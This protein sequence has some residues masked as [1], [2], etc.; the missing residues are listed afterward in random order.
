MQIAG[1][2]IIGG[3]LPPPTITAAEITAR[4]G[5]IAQ[6]ACYWPGAEPPALQQSLERLDQSLILARSAD[7]AALA[8][9]L[10]VLVEALGQAE[11]PYALALAQSCQRDAA[12]LAGGVA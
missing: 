3:I 11:E 8:E 10:T 2:A 9:K 1:D 5:L 6:W 7:P 4:N 12:F